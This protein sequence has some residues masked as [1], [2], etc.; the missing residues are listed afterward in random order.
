MSERDKS[1]KCHARKLA[2]GAIPDVAVAERAKQGGVLVIA[3]PMQLKPEKCNRCG[4]KCE[5]YR[6]GE[7]SM[8]LKPPKECMD[9]MLHPGYWNQL[10]YDVR[11]STKT[12][13]REKRPRRRW[14]FRRPRPS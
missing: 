9:D 14:S 1:S 5:M 4:G 8:F 7:G 11:N 3:T 13:F 12:K 10:V 2:V 6:D